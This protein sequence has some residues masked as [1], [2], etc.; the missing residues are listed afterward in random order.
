MQGFYNLEVVFNSFRPT[1]AQWRHHR[2]VVGIV[3]NREFLRKEKALV[4]L[5]GPIMNLLRM[6]DRDIP[7]TGKVY[8]E[9]FKLGKLLQSMTDSP[10]FDFIPSTVRSNIQSKCHSKLPRKVMRSNGSNGSNW[11]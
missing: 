11:K 7:G 10:E 3:V 1:A 5:C 9:N 8:H 2:A 4:D 6:A